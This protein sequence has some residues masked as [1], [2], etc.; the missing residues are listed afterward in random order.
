MAHQCRSVRCPQEPWLS[1]PTHILGK[2]EATNFNFLVHDNPGV[3]RDHRIETAGKRKCR[4]VSGSKEGQSAHPL[5]HTPLVPQ[6]PLPIS[7]LTLATVPQPPLPTPVSELPSTHRPLFP[8]TVSY[9][10][11][12]LSTAL[13]RGMRAKSLCW[14]TCP[15]GTTPTISLCKAAWISGFFERWYRA[16]VSVLD[17]WEVKR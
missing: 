16:H 17:V 9:R 12:S 5:G 10:R 2:E 14:G 6:S 15:A 3:H 1:S 7:S 13:S 11:V 4:P 8:G